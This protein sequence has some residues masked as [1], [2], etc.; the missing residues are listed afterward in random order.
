MKKI[1]F[2]VLVVLVTLIGCDRFERDFT[3]A[4]RQTDFEKRFVEDGTEYLRAN[5]HDSFLDFYSSAYLNNG[6]SKDGIVDFITSHTWTPDA[7]V[8]LSPEGSGYRVTLRDT[9]IDVDSTWV[10]LTALEVYV[11]RFRGNQDPITLQSRRA[12]ELSFASDGSGYLKDG[13]IDTFMD[14]YSDEYLNNGQEKED[15]EALFEGNTW[16]A[17]AEIIVT[18]EGAGY[19]VVF[20]NA[21]DE[22]FS[23]IDVI[24]L[25]G[26]NV[27]WVGNQQRVRSSLLVI[28]QGF[29]GLWC[30]SCPDAAT[31]Y[32]NLEAMF[33]DNFVYLKY[34]LDIRQDSLVLYNEYREEQNYYGTPNTIVAPVAIYQGETRVNAAGSPAA[35]RA[36][37]VIVRNLILQEAEIELENLN[38]TIHETR[39][40]RDTVKGSVQL[41]FSDLD[42]SNLY[43][44]YTVYQK[45][46]TATYNYAP[47]IY[48]K[49]VVRARGH[50]KL[51]DLADGD[52]VEF[53]LESAEFA[54]RPGRPNPEYRSFADNTYI[55]VWVQRIENI[56]SRQDGDRILNAVK[57][58]LF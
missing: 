28:A 48:A 17:D 4:E 26:D 36:Q 31:A 52:I 19:R 58:N 21:G 5:D 33:P 29:T 6:I 42:T 16:G 13:E 3:S 8:L 24:A 40:P 27:R 20:N 14:Y 37:E 23:W 1:L 55:V 54:T 41:R 12:F 53:E 45:E 34:H 32:S 38:F 9:A 51:L 35:I 18:P 39:K 25:E 7:E 30:T 10:D 11:Y 43:L 57:Q 47:S 49:N 22:V 46:T 56:D 50:H 15:L 2:I 44:F